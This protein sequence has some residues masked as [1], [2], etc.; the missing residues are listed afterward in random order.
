M[1]TILY[2]RITNKKRKENPGYKL[3]IPVDPTEF[4][5]YLFLDKV[6]EIIF[7]VEWFHTSDTL[8][9]N[10]LKDNPLFWISGYL[11]IACM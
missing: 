6:M 3:G 7:V 5:W 8:N 1:V 10:T 4:L 11:I 2:A 9:K